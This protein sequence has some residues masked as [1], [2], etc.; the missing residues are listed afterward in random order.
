MSYLLNEDYINHLFEAG[1]IK[2]KQKANYIQKIK[3]YKSIINNHKQQLKEIQKQVET[4]TNINLDNNIS[5]QKKQIDKPQ[6]YNTDDVVSN[7]LSQ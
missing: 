3:N 5:S 1:I 7:I 6:D 2:E 4:K